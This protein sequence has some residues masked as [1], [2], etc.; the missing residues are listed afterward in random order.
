[1]C[2]SEKGVFEVN[3]LK[4]LLWDRF[5]AERDAYLRLVREKE[6]A[7]TELLKVAERLDLLH[8]LLAL[9]GKKAE[10]PA[11]LPRRKKIA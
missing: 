5:L 7:K 8:R 4:S 3:R 6:E 11:D 2:Q 1:L 9:E 10:L